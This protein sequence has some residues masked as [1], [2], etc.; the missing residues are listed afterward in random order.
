MDSTSILT[1]QE[2]L[3]CGTSIPLWHYDTDGHLL[4]TNAEH[5]VLDKVL[6]FIGGTKYMLEYAQ[7]NRKPLVLS[8][9]MGLMWCAV[10]ESE[11]DCLKSII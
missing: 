11:K 4:E 2:L 7:S 8:S 5:L 9:D 1:M 6:G 3:K 10:F